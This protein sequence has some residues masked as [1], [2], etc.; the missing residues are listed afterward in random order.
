MAR[1]IAIRMKPTTRQP[2]HPAKEIL[3]RP[4]NAQ[5][6]AVIVEHLTS[7]EMSA[8]AAVVT[9]TTR[10]VQYRVDQVEPDVLDAMLGSMEV[11][12]AKGRRSFRR[13]PGTDI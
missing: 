6:T 1:P 8:A 11:E 3:G 4:S 5:A 10:R 13:Y 12:D 7:V 9:A 2:I